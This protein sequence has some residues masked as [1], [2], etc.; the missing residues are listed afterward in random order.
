MELDAF[1]ITQRGGTGHFDI[2]VSTMKAIDIVTRSALDRW[3]PRNPLGYQR[4]LNEK[5]ISDKR[6][7]VLG[8]LLR[9]IGCFPTSILLNVRGEAHFTP[10]GEERWSTRGRLDI[11]EETLWVIDGQHRVEA[12]RRAIARNADFE[13]YP[14]IVSVMHESAKFDELTLFYIVNRRQR[15]ISTD[16]AYR[17]LQ[18]MLWEKGSSWLYDFEGPR[19]VRVG[20]A[21]EV[22]D[23]FNSNPDSP[24]RGR[25][26]RV[27]EVAIPE[28][29]TT[30]RVLASA[31]A[32]VLR[33]KAFVGVPVRD[34]AAGYASYWGELSR[35]YPE[36]FEEPE[37]YLLLSPLGIKAFTLLFAGVY[38]LALEEGPVTSESLVEVLGGLKVRTPGHKDSLF[39]QSIDIGTLE[40]GKKRGFVEL[41]AAEIS[42]GLTEKL[43]LART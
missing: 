6:G 36:A 23:D 14:V 21:S 24:L 4:M 20:L 39:K 18:R 28:Q 35:M 27:G 42:R 33:E 32:E 31:I 38:K 3:E 10:D 30:D 16:L 40:R 37:K 8:Y 11:G 17:H 25:I 22:V 2:Y 1:K 9:E 13:D 41:S 7:G 19:A 5:R 29:V 12:L 34:F 15:G 43:K 26:R